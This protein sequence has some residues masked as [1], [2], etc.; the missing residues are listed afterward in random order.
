[1]KSIVFLIVGLAAVFGSC[2]AADVVERPALLVLPKE[3]PI[4]ASLPLTVAFR[5]EEEDPVTVDT[6]ERGNLLCTSGGIEVFDESGREVPL[7]FPMSLPPIPTDQKK[8]RKGETL[9]LGLHCMGYP[10]FPRPGR[11]Y[12]IASFSG[13]RSDGVKVRFVTTKRWFIVFDAKPSKA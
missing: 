4:H 8:V 12:A 1:M 2:T 11:Y 10:E 7:S 5:W 9:K 3:V 6:F 13:L